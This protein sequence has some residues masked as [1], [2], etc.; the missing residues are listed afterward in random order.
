[1]IAGLQ[2]AV[3]WV[4]LADRK[5]PAQLMVERAWTFGGVSKDLQDLLADQ[6]GT[7][8]GRERQLRC[9]L[10]VGSGG[11]SMTRRVVYRWCT[12]GPGR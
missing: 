5:R 9:N 4:D 8:K 7:P 12:G 2:D 3:S 1:V 11:G 10:M 6:Q